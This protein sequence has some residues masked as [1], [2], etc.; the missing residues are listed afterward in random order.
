MSVNTMRAIDHWVGVPL[1]ALVSPLVALV[2]RIKSLFTPTLEAPKKLLFIELSEMGSAILVDPAMRNAQARGAE[3]FFLIFKSNR[4]SLSLLNT[5]KPENIFTIDS[6]S[7]GGLIK[8]TL[9]F[10]WIARCHKIDTVIDL[11]LFSRFTALLTGLCGAQRR[12]GYHIF[13]GEGLWRGTMLTRKVHYNPHI[14]ITKNFL[15]LIHAAYAKEIEVPFSKIQILDS[16]VRLEQAIIDTQVKNAVLE[17]I[18]KLASSAGIPFA[19]GRQRLILI[20][21]NASDLLPQR[22]WAQAR[23]SELIQS[24]AKHYPDDLILIT[25]SPAEIAYVETVRSVANV[26]HA[27]NF[28][29]QVSFSELP[30]LYT[31]SDVMVT[32]DSGPGHFSAVTPLRTIV[33]FG[34]ETPALYGSLGN[35]ISIT[36]N[37]ACSPCVSAANHRKTPCHNNVCM[38]AISVKQVMEKVELQLQAADLAKQA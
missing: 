1:C 10:L 8:D 32:N 31:L 18:V 16:E 4:A 30:A 14:H 11:E 21:P 35:S 6:S 5:V 2:D 33:L 3:L 17:R 29:G 26:A 34:P 38:Q 20:N 23:F 25:G 9:R 7:L 22:R 37:L 12:V 24:I 15:S 19:H 27:L 13:H 36:A 28:A